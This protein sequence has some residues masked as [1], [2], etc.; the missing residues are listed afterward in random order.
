MS[1]SECN[2]GVFCWV[3]PIAEGVVLGMRDAV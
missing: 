1:L 2:S 3:N